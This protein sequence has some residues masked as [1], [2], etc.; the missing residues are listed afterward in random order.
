MISSLS[1][2][3]LKSRM[4]FLKPLMMGNVQR[5]GTLVSGDL[6]SDVG[7]V[8]DLAVLDDQL[9]L[10]P[11]GHNLDPLAVWNNLDTILVPLG[12]GVVLL[13]INLEG[14][15]LAFDHVLALQLAGEGVLEL[16]HLQLA[17]GSVLALL[18]ELAVDLASPFASIRH[19]CGPDLQ[20]AVSTLVLYQEP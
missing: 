8:V 7:R 15:S 19:L 17:A 12:G 6:A 10:L 13:D 5:C 14:G 4:P 1:T 16:L 20:T 18:G 3:C 2:H 11:L 9:P